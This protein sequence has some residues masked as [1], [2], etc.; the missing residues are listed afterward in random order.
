MLSH[1]DMLAIPFL[2][3][4]LFLPDKSKNKIR[5]ILL[6]SISGLVADLLFTFIYKKKEYKY[7]SR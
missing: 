5:M 4:V 7:V 2:H 6:F 3:F 1:F